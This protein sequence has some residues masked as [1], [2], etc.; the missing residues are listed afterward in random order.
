MKTTNAAKRKVRPVHG[1]SIRFRCE[2]IKTPW[3]RSS[4]HRKCWQLY[5]FWTLRYWRKW[6]KNNF[7]Q[8]KSS[9]RGNGVFL[10]HGLRLQ[11]CLCV[12]VRGFRLIRGFCYDF[13]VFDRSAVIHVNIQVAQHRNTR[14]FQSIYS[15]SL[16]RRSKPNLIVRVEE[17]WNHYS[18]SQDTARTICMNCSIWIKS[19]PQ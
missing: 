8:S 3:T 2:N 12:F 1:F 7:S 9:Y 11:F 4:R 13:R 17:P 16:V 15:Q 10:R 19:P 5:I 18:T 6:I 14:C